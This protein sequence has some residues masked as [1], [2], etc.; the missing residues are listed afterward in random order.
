M[1]YNDVESGAFATRGPNCVHDG[2]ISY[3]QSSLCVNSKT[4]TNLCTK[5]F[6]PSKCINA[7]RPALERWWSCPC[8]NGAVRMYGCMYGCI[9]QR[10]MC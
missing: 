7:C 2:R 5:A 1:L 9:R 10:P 8:N 3:K 6:S 4:P